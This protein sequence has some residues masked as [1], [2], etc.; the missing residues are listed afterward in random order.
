MII[1]GEKA[2]LKSY[3]SKLNSDVNVQSEIGK[4][5]QV[6]KAETNKTK[7][8]RK[9]SKNANNDIYRNIRTKA[10]ILNQD[11]R[12]IQE[13][14]SLIQTQEQE[15]QNMEKILKQVKSNYIEAIENGKQEEI[16]EKVKIRKIQKEVENLTREYIVE[17]E[18]I[19]DDSKVLDEIDESLKKINDIKNKLTR[20]KA[21]LISLE[22]SVSKNKQEVLH[23][24]NRV[25]EYISSGE[26]INEKIIINPLDFIFIDTDKNGGIIINIYV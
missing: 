13:K 1:I 14:V 21:K 4:Q 6:Q 26:A 12:D 5:I 2:Y 7:V 20:Y 9:E 22:N 24:S 3:D 11:H 23:T 10:N 18:Y 8:T 15:V 25:E 17:N 16:R 19:K